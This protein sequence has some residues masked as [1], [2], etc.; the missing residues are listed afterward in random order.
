VSP[1]T[2]TVCTH[3]ELEAINRSLVEGTPNR[4]IAS[5]YDVTERAVRNHKAAH[6][7]AALAKAQEAREVAHAD[8]LL[9][10][11]RSLQER[12]LTI[13]DKA[14][15]SGDL[16]TALSAIREARGNLELLAKLLGELDERSVNVLVSPEWLELR[17]VI[18]TALEPHPEAR[19]AVL[20]ALQGADNGRA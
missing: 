20:R 8:E 13:L 14:E 12:V 11:V 15:A 17:A 6:L 16:R 2:C 19:G 7:P 10:D 18:V 5:Q 1:R 3:P 4:R 9:S